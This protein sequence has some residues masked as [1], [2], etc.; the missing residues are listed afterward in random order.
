M[1]LELAVGAGAGIAGAGVERVDGLAG[2]F[3]GVGCTAG[4]QS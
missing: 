4:G 2:I 3:V 1:A